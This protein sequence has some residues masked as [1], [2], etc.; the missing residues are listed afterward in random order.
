MGAFHGHSVSLEVN[1]RDAICGTVYPIQVSLTAH[2]TIIVANG[3]RTKVITETLVNALHDMNKAAAGPVFVTPHLSIRCKW[4]DGHPEVVYTLIGDTARP[5][6][7]V[8]LA[9]ED[10]R[11]KI[12]RFV[13][14]DLADW[15]AKVVGREV[16]QGGVRHL[17]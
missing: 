14:V 12:A 4:V 16:L 15:K 8:S 9:T 5:L 13:G 7:E 1:V 10:D 11:A 3:W 17:H 2:Q 6:A